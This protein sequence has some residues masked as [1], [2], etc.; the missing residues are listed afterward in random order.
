MSTNLHTLAGTS[1]AT[2]STAVSATVGGLDVYD[3]LL[4]YSELTQATGGVLD[5]YI[6]TLLHTTGNSSA[7][8]WVDY[9]H[10][11]QLSAGSTVFRRVWSVSRHAQQ[12]T[13][14]T[15]GTDTTP[16]LAA[17]AILG[18]EWGSWW[19]LAFVAGASTSAGAV[20]TVK[21]LGRRNTFR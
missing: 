5:I 15:I 14:T 7:G 10:F 13:L 9:A 18:G 4:I 16:A 6:Q 19:R 11:P 3:S 12:T 21:I 20:Q 1:P 2:A 17:N 8:T